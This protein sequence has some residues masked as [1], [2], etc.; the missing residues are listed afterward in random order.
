[1]IPPTKKCGRCQQRKA[2]CEFSRRNRRGRTELQGRCKACDAEAKRKA[3]R[4]EVRIESE[5]APVAAIDEDCER[6]YFFTREEKGR[7]NRNLAALAV[8]VKAGRA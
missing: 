4:R 5:G 1:M 7:W 3:R 8:K 2:A 6:L